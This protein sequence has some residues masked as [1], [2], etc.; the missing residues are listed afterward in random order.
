M[1]RVSLT[2]LQRGVLD[3][4]RNRGLTILAELAQRK[5]S[6]GEYCVLSLAD[7]PRLEAD[8]DRANA[9]VP[10]ADASRTAPVGGT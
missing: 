7:H 9:Q 8:F 5:W 1:A 6:N 10:S 3:R 2:N 4:M